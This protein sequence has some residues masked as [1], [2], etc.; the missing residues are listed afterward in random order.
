M[1]VDRP[2][3][4]EQS[5]KE[6]LA[7]ADA[8]RPALLRLSRALRRETQR[9]GVSAVDAQILGIVKKH[10]GIGVSELAEREQ[11][12]SASMSIHVKRLVET[13]WIERT[14]DPGEDRR[15]AGLKLSPQGVRAM[16]AIRR[17]RNDWLAARIAGLSPAARAVLAAAAEPLMQLTEDRT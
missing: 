10:P 1:K 5:S 16:E 3:A 13:G 2:A 12:S 4:G 8:L 9:A 6:I 14:A 11:V 7:L 17:R 15:R